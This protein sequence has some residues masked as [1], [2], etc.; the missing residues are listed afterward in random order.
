MAMVQSFSP[1]THI[2]RVGSQNHITAYKRIKIRISPLIETN[3]TLKY[4]KYFICQANSVKVISQR[5]NWRE[6]MQYLKEYVNDYLLKPNLQILMDRKEP[7]ST[8]SFATSL[9]L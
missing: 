2:L 7:Q 1:S 8:K 5:I 4:H 3:H 9:V 6:G